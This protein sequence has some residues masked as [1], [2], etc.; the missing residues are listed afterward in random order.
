MIQKIKPTVL[1]RRVFGIIIR[2]DILGA[3]AK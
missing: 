2:F 1:L 3:V